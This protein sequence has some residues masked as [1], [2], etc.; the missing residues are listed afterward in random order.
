MHLK[1]HVYLIDFFSGWR[2]VG[3][4]CQ[5]R[6]Y[7]KKH[8]RAKLFI[9]GW[10]RLAKGWRKKSH[11]IYTCN[12]LNYSRLAKLTKKLHLLLYKTTK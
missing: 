2:K 7:I 3:E 1:K 12:A 4:K 8:M 10:R 11:K 5:Y 6:K 9:A